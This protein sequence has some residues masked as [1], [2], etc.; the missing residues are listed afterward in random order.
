MIESGEPVGQ[1]QARDG[2]CLSGSSADQ[3]Y[4]V[5]LSQ[6]GGCFGGAVAAE[7]QQGVRG[8]K[9][10]KCQRESTEGDRL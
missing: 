10:G 7:K 2:D 1:T 4:N 6:H 5:T 8:Q 3:R 9:V